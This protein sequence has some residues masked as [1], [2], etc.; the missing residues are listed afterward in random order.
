MAEHDGLSHGIAS[1]DD[2]EPE[3]AKAKKF[4]VP[5]IQIRKPRR[6]QSAV[7]SSDKDARFTVIGGDKN[8]G[9]LPGSVSAQDLP[10]DANGTVVYSG[11]MP[12]LSVKV[13]HG[14]SLIAMSGSVGTG[15]AAINR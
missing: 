7:F 8:K 15:R 12:V 1:M 4:S 11:A 5:S 2:P 10:P 13:P 6:S 14:E 3:P 9:V